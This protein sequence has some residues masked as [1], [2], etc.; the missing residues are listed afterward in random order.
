MAYTGKATDHLG[1]TMNFSLPLARYRFLAVATSA[2]RFPAYSGS[3]WRGVLGSALRKTV[4]ITREPTCKNCLLQRSCVYSQ[5]FETP[6][7][8]Q[9]LLEKVNTAPHPYIL[10][11][12]ATC[13]RHY[14]PGESLELSL[15]LIG[16]AIAHLPYLIH[17][18]QQA[19]VNGLGKGNGQFELIEVQQEQPVGSQ[20]WQ[21]IY[22]PNQALSA[23]PGLI[24][25]I[26]PLPTT[27]LAITFRT[28][29]RRLQDG[30]LIHANHF[31]FQG[32]ITGLIRRISLLHSFHTGVHLQADF[33]AL[34]AQAS[35]VS[36]SEVNLYT[37]HWERYSNRQ[38]TKI[39]MDGLLGSFE[40]PAGEALAAFWP[41]LWLGQWL[42]A[43]KGVVMGMGEYRLQSSQT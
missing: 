5:V 43:G 27:P 26:P 37:Y 1:I 17:A 14:E 11:P 4:C 42:H 21:T 33:K 23:Q 22:R 12:L 20:D 2:L 34:S 39:Q 29:Y 36:M 35:D 10:H 13:G 6:A 38:Q 31:T 28:P 41:W 32:F 7:V 3:T 30:K 40:I 8:Q 16:S 24:P 19:G 15:T 25:T 9:P 18:L